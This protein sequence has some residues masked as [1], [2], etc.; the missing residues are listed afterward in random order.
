MES[1]E[2][3]S[4]ID[5]NGGGG[6]KSI[7]AGPGSAGSGGSGGGG[8]GAVGYSNPI[9][10]TANTGGGGGG[11]GWNGVDTYGAIGGS[12]IVILSIPT[13]SYTGTT[14]GSPTVS[15]Y[16]SNTILQ[17]TSSGTYVA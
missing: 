13:V 10:G 6:G 5:L 11:A 7:F 2:R 12:G 1:D 8:A 16:G 3:F 9:A 15:T 17:Y 4:T 14:S